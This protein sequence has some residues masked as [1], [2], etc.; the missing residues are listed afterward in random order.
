MAPHKIMLS[1]VFA[2]KNVGVK[3]VA[4]RIWLGRL[5]HEAAVCC[6]ATSGRVLK[7][8]RTLGAPRSDRRP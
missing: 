2:G 3:Q 6:G 8:L 5:W 4:D 7:M 1:T